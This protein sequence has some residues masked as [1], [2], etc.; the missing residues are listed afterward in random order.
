MAYTDIIREFDH[1]QYIPILQRM[2][3]ANSVEEMKKYASFSQTERFR[4][5]LETLQAFGLHKQMDIQP[6]RS[7]EEQTAARK[8]SDGKV[9]AIFSVS[10]AKVKESYRDAQNKKCYRRKIKNAFIEST[11]IKSNQ[12]LS[13]SEKN[14]PHCM[15]CGASMQVEGENYLCPFCRTRYRAEAYRYVMTK[16]FIEQPLRNLRFICFILVPAL[17]LAILQVSGTISQQQWQSASLYIS[18]VVAIFVTALFFFALAKGLRDFFAHQG[19]KKKIRSHDPNF[20]EEVFTLRLNNLL[21]MQP[22]ILCPSQEDDRGATGVI[23]RNVLRLNFCSYEQQGDL[24]VIECCGKLDAL[25]LKGRPGHVE[26][27]DRHKKVSLRLA[28]TYG[29][30]TPVLYLPD[31]FTCRNCGSHQMT[32]QAGM[33]VCRFCHTSIPMED[34]DWILY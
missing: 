23:C 5:E 33:Q 32:E 2:Y 34:L 15:N 13:Y 22:E 12:N 19:V 25:F 28:R 26:L 3:E 20:S 30:L 6:D 10:K 31:Q 24:E 1:L 9:N 7:Q 29:T 21:A 16:F 18:T 17:I 8:Y 11:V 14:P 27:K 4:R